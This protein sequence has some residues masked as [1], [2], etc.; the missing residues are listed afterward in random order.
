MKKNNKDDKKRSDSLK[1]IQFS[2]KQK[3]NIQKIFDIKDISEFVPVIISDLQIPQK[4]L[5]E[6]EYEKRVLPHNDL[7]EI[8]N[9]KSKDDISK[10]YDG[11]VIDFSRK[12]FQKYKEI[13]ELNIL[14][15]EENWQK[16]THLIDLWDFIF[17]ISPEKI[18]MLKDS[19][20]YQEMKDW[21]NW[22]RKM[23]IKTVLILWNHDKR[24]YV[25]Q[26]YDFFDNVYDFLFLQK[27]YDTLNIDEKYTEFE[28]YSHY[29]ITTTLVW[30][31][32]TKG[33]EYWILPILNSWFK[34]VSKHWHTHSRNIQKT[35]REY[36]NWVVY[37]NYCLD[38]Q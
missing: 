17:N 5:F 16:P 21:F 36:V 20:I 1:K 27:D 32:K 29:P 14:L 37:E 10:L 3:N 24:N 9:I 38:N 7:M 31:F 28:F 34:I 30:N 8:H 2:L 35:S 12:S 25:S 11:W 18:D 4:N 26:Y 15:L 13:V 23:G 19:W 6:Y 33:D 22:I